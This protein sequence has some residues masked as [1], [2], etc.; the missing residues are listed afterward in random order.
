MWNLRGSREA[1]KNIPNRRNAEMGNQ[2]FDVSVATNIEIMEISN[3]I[4]VDQFLEFSGFKKSG[5]RI[6]AGIIKFLEFHL[7]K[8]QLRI[9]QNITTPLQQEIRKLKFQFY[10]VFG[11]K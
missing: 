2:L 4:S 7:R 5:C 9:L 1:S 6:Q 10:F 8:A 11:A 3:V